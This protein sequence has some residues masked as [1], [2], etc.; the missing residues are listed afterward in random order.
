MRVYHGTIA[1]YAES[2]RCTGLKPCPKNA[3]RIRFGSGRAVRS[4]ERVQWAYVSKDDEAARVYA[5]FR[6]KY[7]T[8]R[9]G[10]SIEH[11]Y[12]YVAP[13]KLGRKRKASASPVIIVFNL[14]DGWKLADDP[15][16]NE[17][18]SKPIPP[19]FIESILPVQD[20]PEIAQECK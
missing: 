5:K 4:I 20:L 10:A 8:A 2:I 11:E 1:E 3:F 7:E 18:V 12:C 15:L 13:K 9:T 19:E 14:P 17:C 16:S 6:A